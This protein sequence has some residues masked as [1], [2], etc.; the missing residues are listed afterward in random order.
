VSTTTGTFDSNSVFMQLFAIRRR[1][2]SVFDNA[3]ERVSVRLSA[4]HHLGFKWHAGRDSYPWLSG[5]N[6]GARE[7][8]NVYLASVA[9][10]PR[11]HGGKQEAG[12]RRWL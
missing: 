9:W 8:D 4:S 7:S 3:K 10:H 5:S 6:P 1:S 11:A 2:S 12:V